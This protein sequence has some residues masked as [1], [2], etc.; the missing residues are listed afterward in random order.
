METSKPDD[1]QSVSPIRTAMESPYTSYRD[2]DRSHNRSASWSFTP[3]PQP[4]SDPSLTSPALQL[5]SVIRGFVP[6]ISPRQD[7]TPR[8][9]STPATNSIRETDTVIDIESGRPGVGVGEAVSA[10]SSVQTSLNRWALLAGIFLALLAFKLLWHHW[11]GLALWIGLHL[12]LYHCNKMLKG[13]VALREKKQPIKLMIV[14]A[15]LLFNLFLIYY[16]FSQYHLYT[17]L[18]FSVPPGHQSF[19]FWTIIW[20]VLVTDYIVRYFIL[21]IKSSICLLGKPPQLSNRKKGTV[22]L[23]LEHASHLYRLLI[24][25]HIWLSYFFR[26]GEAGFLCSLIVSILYVLFKLSAVFFKGKELYAAVQD[27]SKN[28]SY[29]YMGRSESGI[30]P[31]CQEEYMEPVKLLC[32]HV[33]CDG[34]VSIW[35][36]RERTCP[37]CRTAVASDPQWRDGST[38]LLPYF[39]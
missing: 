36:D 1:S 13:Q 6:G 10:V 24:P 11:V 16:T 8:P 37:L 32:T 35:F 7:P 27:I 14:M 33:F 5:A 4:I 2:R 26:N 12:L 23:I 15:F 39:F 29:L 3:N 31:I 38:S 28:W 9:S 22:Y 17:S 25:S 30:C 18:Y 21:L 34:C 19:D 20:V